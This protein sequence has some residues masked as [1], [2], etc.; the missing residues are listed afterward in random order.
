M[1]HAKLGASG[2]PRWIPCPGSVKACE[3]LQDTSGIWAAI[4]TAAHTLGEHCL[5]NGVSVESLRGTKIPAKRGR[6]EVDDAMIAGVSVYVSAIR[7]ELL[8]NLGAKLS[9]ERKFDLSK[10]SADFIGLEMFGTNDAS[11]INPSGLLSIWDYKNGKGVGVEVENNYQLMFYA[12]GGFL[13]ALQEG[14][15]I[16]MIE[17]VVVQPNKPHE[18]GPVRRWRITPSDL[19]RWAKEVLLPAAKEAM[20]D[21]PRFN[22][23]DHCRKYFCKALKQNACPALQNHMLDLVPGLDM[24]PDTK[25]S[26]P[27]VESLSDIDRVKLV[28]GLDLMIEYTKAVKSSIKN[29]LMQGKAVEGVK[30]VQGRKGNRAWD[31]ERHYEIL[32]K[33]GSFEGSVAPSKPVS[34]AALEKIVAAAGC[35]FQEL[36]GEFVVQAKAGYSVV[37]ANSKKPEV[38]APLGF[39]P[40]RGG[41]EK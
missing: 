5:K 38:P 25:N 9:L 19:M 37:P 22:P 35:D 17:L 29:D 26:F 4:G 1:K 15:M 12:V 7:A 3:P 32:E 21:N 39:D 2:A 11:I 40:I 31:A 27:P 23:G 16:N 33:A 10:L 24:I 8:K 14:H 6:Y 41:N 20:S 34:P 28:S 13:S 36:F 18:D 30:L